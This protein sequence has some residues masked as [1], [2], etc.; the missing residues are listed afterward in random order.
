MLRELPDTC[1]MIGMAVGQQNG[2]DI[3]NRMP[4]AGD[5]GSNSAKTFFPV[6]AGIDED[7]SFLV[8][9]YPDICRCWPAATVKFEEE[10][11]L[12]YRIQLVHPIRSF[13]VHL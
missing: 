3:L 1:D 6:E 7:E 11:I 12:P 4:G 2:V 13:P 8:D 10:K 5:T 9:D